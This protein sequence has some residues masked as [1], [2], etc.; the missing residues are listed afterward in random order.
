MGS[1]GDPG[2]EFCA[3]ASSCSLYL[4]G[5]KAFLGLVDG[6]VAAGS[7]MVSA[8]F[9]RGSEDVVIVVSIGSARELAEIG[10]G[11]FVN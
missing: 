11:E 6:L 4:I 2:G 8:M 9:R 5:E 10:A 3:L 1:A 7:D